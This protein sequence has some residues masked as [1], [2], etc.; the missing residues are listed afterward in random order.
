MRF[1]L[2]FLLFFT[3]SFSNELAK[4]TSPYLLQHKDNPVNWME[5]SD[6]AF[7]KAKEE[8]KFIFLSIGYS[9]CH[10]CH[11]MA[12]ESFSNKEVADILNKYFVSIKVDKE[13]L[14]DIDSYYQLAYQLVNNK[15]GG[16]P[17]TVILLPNRKPIY[18]GTYMPKDEL[19]DLLKKIVNT[20]KEK[21]EQIANDIDN[22]LKRYQ[23]AKVK[24][25]DLKK[26]LLLRAFEG[27]KSYYDFK[28][29]GFGNAPKFPQPSSIN[30]LLNIYLITD[31]KE[32]L[33]MATDMLDAMAKGGIY[34][35][36]DGGFFRYSVDAKWQIPHFEKMLYTNAELISVYSKAYKITKSKLYAKVVKE[37]I[38]EIDKRFLYKGLYYSASNADSKDE[39]GVEREGYYYIYNYDKALDYLVKKGISKVRAKEVLKYFGIEPG[40]NF[41]DGEYSLAHLSK[42][43]PIYKREKHLLSELRAKK[44]YPFIDKKINTA[45]NAL[46][47]KAKI[48]ARVIDKTY[49]KEAIASLHKLLEVMQNRDKELYHQ[50]LLPHKA[51]QKGMLEDYAFVAD[52]LF[53]AYEATL[54]DL[55]LIEFK[56]IVNLSVNKFYKGNGEWLLS[57]NKDVVV[58]AKIDDGSYKSPLATNLQNMI[59]ST[60]LGGDYKLIDIAEA[61]IKNSAVFIN[62]APYLY[63]TALDA[64]TMLNN[65]IYII[66]GPKQGLLKESLDDIKYP[67]VYKKGETAKTIKEYQICGLKSCYYSNFSIQKVKEKLKELSSKNK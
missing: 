50:T 17:L 41:E 6:K 55:Y 25:A 53:S 14:S 37:S 4:S 52:A 58:K 62:K 22:L 5:W 13:R 11:V 21:L 12:K 7:K 60:A 29:K 45:W 2:I 1:L 20:K 3:F 15:A 64:I 66:K 42:F 10:W 24:K 36:I 59:K 63:P 44:E 51:A 49:A 54:D 16:W 40:G 43:N 31:N 61:T 18:F 56:N 33:K 39:N 65:G 38:K 8:N 30:E 46:Y 67:F 57:D 34:D 47:I 35:Q 19:I 23:N 32:A 28:N 9:T 27:F 26:D 48:D